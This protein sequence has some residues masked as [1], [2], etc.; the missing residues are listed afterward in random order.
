[1]SFKIWNS[2]FNIYIS[3]S[4]RKIENQY[5]S[6]IF[7]IKTPIHINVTCILS[8]SLY[9]LSGVILHTINK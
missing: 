9:Y 6:K 4:N 7:Q 1:M 3:Q 5:P 2:R 8:V